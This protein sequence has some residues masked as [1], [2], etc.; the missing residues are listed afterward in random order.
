MQ[1]GSD[2]RQLTSACPV[3]KLGQKNDLISFCS[4]EWPS[5]TNFAFLPLF[6]LHE[7]HFHPLNLHAVVIKICIHDYMFF[8]FACLYIF[9]FMCLFLYVY[10]CLS[11]HT[12]EICFSTVIIQST[13][14]SWR[15]F[16]PD[17]FQ[18]SVKNGKCVK[19]TAECTKYIKIF[20]KSL[21]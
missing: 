19:K 16:S 1:I 7:Y 8:N 17:D 6:G 9:S 15:L 21:I 10:V 18:T 3:C 4:L 5:L 13:V 11:I 14:F 20:L 12:S 2:F